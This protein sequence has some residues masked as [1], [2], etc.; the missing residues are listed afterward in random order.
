[1]PADH[2][3]PGRRRSARPRAPLLFAYG[4]LMRG[5]PLHGLL[6]GRARL[7]GEGTVEGTLL[8]LG[9]YPGLVEGGGRVRGELYRLEVPELLAAIDRAEGYNFERRLTAVTR[10]AGRR[11]RAWTYW[12]RGPRDCAV[13]IPEGDW[14][15]RWR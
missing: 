2:P 13:P 6:A 4:T 7:V 10:A 5:F 11:V 1:M 3:G 9:R 12:Y 15:S 14:R 8:H